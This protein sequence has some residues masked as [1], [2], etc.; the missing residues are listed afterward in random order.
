MKNFVTFCKLGAVIILL[1]LAGCGKKQLASAPT[2]AEPVMKAAAMVDLQ[3]NGDF[4]K[5]QPLVDACNV[6][7]KAGKEGVNC[8]ELAKGNG[9]IAELNAR[10]PGACSPKIRF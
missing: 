6:E 9:E 1:S 3:C 8:A 7:K 10:T 4:T 5:I 2:A